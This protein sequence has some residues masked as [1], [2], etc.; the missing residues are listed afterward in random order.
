[1]AY[2]YRDPRS[3]RDDHQA[4]L[5][6]NPNPLSPQRHPN[7]LSGGML[8]ANDVRAGLTRR[9]TTNALPTLSP[10]GQQRSQLAGGYAVSSM[11]CRDVCLAVG[12]AKRDPRGMGMCDV[13][14]KTESKHMS[15][16]SDTPLSWRHTEYPHERFGGLR[17]TIGGG[18]S[19]QGAKKQVDWCPSLG[20]VFADGP[21]HSGVLRDRLT[22][23]EQP[24]GYARKTTVRISPRSLLLPPFFV[25]LLR[26]HPFALGAVVTTHPFDKRHILSHSNTRSYCQ[27]AFRADHGC[28]PTQQLART[29]IS[30]CNSDY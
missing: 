8:P 21:Q 17:G 6:S 10:I 29:K 24:A 22:G 25:F 19:L 26:P 11:F 30:S 28:R 16:L 13:E 5:Y 20:R 9:F 14:E 12:G 4:P 18:A 7:R 2:P 15:S 27:H 3:P 23:D 1:M